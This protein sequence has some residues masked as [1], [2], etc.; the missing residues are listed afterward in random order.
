MEEETKVDKVSTHSSYPD[1]LAKDIDDEKLKQI[2]SD[3]CTEYKLDLESRSEWEND[4]AKWLRMFALKPEFKEKKFPF[5]K[6]SNIVPPLITS[7]CLQF[8]ARA[9]ESIIPSKN[10][11]T[12]KV[13]DGVA[14]NAGK[15]VETHM[16][17]QLR[18][19]MEEWEEDF[20]KLLI[21]LP[22][23]GSSYKKVFYDP[24]KKRNVSCLLTVD[25]L[26]TPYHVR[27]LEDS[28]R[29]TQ[30][31]TDLL[32]NI[33]ANPGYINTDDL[34]SKQPIAQNTPSPEITEAQADSVGQE[35]STDGSDGVRQLLE[36]HKYLDLGEGLKRYILTIDLETE[37]V[38]RIDKGWRK[39]E[40]TKKD[41]P[42]VRFISFQF[43]PNPDSHYGYGFG[44][45]MGPLNAMATALINQLIDSGTL[46]NTS[47]MS[48]FVNKRS[49]VKKG[50]VEISLGHFKETDAAVDDL[51]K[52]I[53]TLDFNEPSNV[54]F[55]LLG[56]VQDWARTVS[57]V[58]DPL[59]GVAPAS[60]TG[61]TAFLAAIEQGQKVFNSIHKRIHRSFKKELKEIRIL[62]SIYVD[63][64]IYLAVQD[65][66]LDI[67]N[68]FTSAKNDY[69][70]VF[71][72]IP[73]SDPSI[74]TRAERI[75][76][77]KIAY[78]VGMNDPLVAENPEA[79]YL[80]L[81]ELYE[82]LGTRNI[83]D[84]VQKPEPQEPEDLPPV[85]E[86]AGF[87]MEVDSAVLP[88]Q[89]HQAH[90]DSHDIFKNSKFGDELTPQ[91]QKL[92]ENHVRQH[93]AELYKQEVQGGF[94]GGIEGG[95]GEIDGNE[96]ILGGVAGGIPEPIGGDIETGELG[97]LFAGEGAIVPS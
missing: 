31:Y 51:R 36:Q 6:A 50:E 47:K 52:A 14:V 61:S 67:Y 93:L 44:H 28:P 79:R 82:A 92:L 94:T 73:V 72:V 59:T 39:N 3:A 20:D 81:V 30:Y 77:A 91:G 10:V 12:C 88:E 62:N 96:D 4:R 95:M 22:L 84:I 16:N 58:Q 55:S 33:K 1:N 63:Q 13:L 83:Q 69:K 90:I 15:R 85:E 35:E 41:E 71:D 74:T 80:L 43:V 78:D 97:E 45:I 87:L 7:A 34:D 5:D 9:Y 57:S 54:L 89:D 65:S 70:A 2:G 8:Q 25:E 86:E 29:I 32:V 40:Y 48:G 37:K 11:V 23:N 68:D 17:W 27:R 18:E 46:A 76:K 53:Y 75:E 64:K 60:D 56:F 42:A 21:D 19:E 49:G 26:I 66:Q 24:I 38:L